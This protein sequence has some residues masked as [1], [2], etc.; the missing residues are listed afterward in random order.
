LNA[1][2]LAKNIP[3]QFGALTFLALFSVCLSAPGTPN[4]VDLNDIDGGGGLLVRSLITVAALVLLP[5]P[6]HGA[7]ATPNRIVYWGNVNTAQTVRV[8]NPDA[9]RIAK[10]EVERIGGSGWILLENSTAIGF[11]AAFCKKAG[12]QMQFFVV[13]GLPTGREAVDAAK[14]KAGGG[15]ALCNN[16]LWRVSP[17]PVARPPAGADQVID[18][19][20]GLIRRE[21][22]PERDF[23][24]DCLPPAD[25][26]R[27]EIAPKA[28]GVTRPKDTRP[29]APAW[30]PASWC[31]PTGASSGKRG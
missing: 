27:A 28:S 20:Q 9:E 14:K 16:A 17:V 15:S 11:G 7:E 5:S 29:P 26:A 1:I 30:K 13:H 25:S 2:G 8:N 22:A 18:A 4:L 31:P 6:L 21:V 3:R 10:A 19:T 24:S 23:S 12:S